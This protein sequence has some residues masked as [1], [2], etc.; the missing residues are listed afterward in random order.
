MMAAF[1]PEPEGCLG[2]WKEV[3]IDILE[4]RDLG[5]KSPSLEGRG[6]WGWGALSRAAL[7][8]PT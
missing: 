1:R 5:D 3:Q 6:G 8:F 7:T 4:L 2:S